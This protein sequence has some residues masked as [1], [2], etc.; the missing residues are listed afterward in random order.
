[1]N[2]KLQIFNM[3]IYNESSSADEDDVLLLTAAINGEE[4]ERYLKVI[5]H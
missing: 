4:Q 2:N 5:I 3:D 1:M